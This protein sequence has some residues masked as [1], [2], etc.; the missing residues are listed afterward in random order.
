M[1]GRF[2]IS[3]LELMH[4]CF[5]TPD[6]PLGE[7][8]ERL[9]HFSDAPNHS[10]ER[11]V[12]SGTIELVINLQDDEIRVYD[13]ESPGQCR[14]FSGSVA[15]GAYG[16]SFVIDTREHASILGVHFRPGGAAPLF[17]LPV[18]ELRDRH[19]DLETLWG[20]TARELRERLCNATT[21]AGRFRLLERAL[22]SRLPSSP[23]RHPAVWFALDAF[24][25]A[26]PGLTVGDIA[27]QSG[28][29]QRRFIQ[30]FKHYSNTPPPCG[31]RLRA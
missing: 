27:E 3:N 5:K 4:P 13:S 9:W 23:A 18:S 6:P 31:G 26:T 16:K 29:S 21:L 19:V 8:V 10:R 15:S 30:A 24:S 12:P 14:R 22:A 7:F 17:R 28:F 25:R 2:W 11:I 20:A 1:V